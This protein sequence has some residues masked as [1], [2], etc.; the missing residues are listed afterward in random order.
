M[1]APSS[2]AQV[3]VRRRKRRTW[4]GCMGAFG[5]AT[6]V[7]TRST[8]TTAR[9]TVPP[10]RDGANQAD[11]RLRGTL[12][13]PGAGGYPDR[14]VP[15]GH[16]SEHSLQASRVAASWSAMSR[17]PRVSSDEEAHLAL[18]DVEEL[19]VRLVRVRPRPRLPGIQP[20]LRDAVAVFG[21]SAVGLEH[22]MHRSGVVR[23]SRTRS[24][25]D[26]FPDS[27]IC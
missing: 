24:Q 26:R 14:I 19:L 13:Y 21:L 16:R 9:R 10:A 27:F 20:P 2:T 23:T 1:I 5:L 8:T 7:R 6:A 17:G 22:R 15:A 25:E 18:D 11:L 4:Y 12:A 3:T